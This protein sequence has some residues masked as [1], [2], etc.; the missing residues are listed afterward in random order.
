M[1]RNKGKPVKNLARKKSG[2]RKSRKGLRGTSFSTGPRKAPLVNRIAIPGVID[3]W[4]LVPPQQGGATHLTPMIT[5]T[6]SQSWG[7]YFPGFDVS[8]V[9]SLGVRS[10]NVTMNVAVQ[11]P[12]AGKSPKPYQLRV[13]QGW[14]KQPVVGVNMTS[15]AGV[16]GMSDGI[17]LNFDPTVVFKDHVFQTMF[18]NI[19]TTIGQLDG[20]G[21]VNSDNVKVISDTQHLITNTSVTPG[22][23]YVFPTFNRVYNFRTGKRMRL[24]P[25]TTGGAIP[26][27][28][29]PDGY[30][31]FN[32]PGLW[33]PAIALIML[34]YNDY[35][36]DDDRPQVYVQQSHYWTNM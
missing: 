28:G 10:R 21:N 32:N 5:L 13:I 15:T 4:Q 18:D 25:F 36:A 20:R 17:A 34:N 3:T 35:T 9:N 19:G 31:P 14:V 30:S 6:P 8:Q 2:P 22:G 33:I 12:G 24:Y 16:S 11:F 1:A 29:L 26:A 27:S 23:D 7:R